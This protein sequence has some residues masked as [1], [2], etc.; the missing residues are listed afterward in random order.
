MSRKPSLLSRGANAVKKGF[1]RKSF[2]LG[3]YSVLATA[4]VIAI[5]IA[6]NLLVGA[7]PSVYTKLDT[8]NQELFTITEQTKKIVS[9]LEADVTVYWIVQNGAENS[10][11]SE[12][13]DRY[14]SLSGHL[15]VVKRD[16]VVHPNFAGQYTSQAVYNNSLV[17]ES[18]ER[19]QYISFEDIVVTDY[20]DYYYTGNYTQEFAG[21]SALTSAI[22][23]VTSDSL[24]TVYL[25]SGHGEA[26]LNETVQSAIEKEN[27]VLQELSLLT[28]ESVPED[29]D[30]VMVIS[31]QTDLS[32]R[33]AEMLLAYLQGGGSLLMLTDY[34][35]SGLPTLMGIMEQYGV[36]AVD[37]IVV[38]GDSYY[39]L[40]GYPYYL[41]PELTT[42][43]IT[44]PLMEGGYSAIMPVAQ[45]LTV[46]SSPRD[47]LSITQLLTT[48]STAYAK[49]SGYGM[50]THEKEEGDIDGPFALGVAIEEAV[51]EGT[52]QIAWFTSSQM[53]DDG[54]N[55]LVSGA[56]HNLFINALDWMCERENSISIRT[57]SLSSET[58]I[59]PDAA[60]SRWS[61]VMIGVIPAVILC[62]GLVVMVTRRRR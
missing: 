7:I 54:I 16:P 8:T 1:T 41:L 5:V 29:A 2:R 61:I 19:S 48:S 30:C 24:P 39:Y 34:V 43:A 58:L 40:W 49:L 45:G 4:I 38:E 37:G 42:H 13:L 14:A 46:D 28:V 50:T 27:F 12:L 20:S 10:L 35:E 18:G 22:D 33:E 55:Q 23:Y 44:T 25:L 56:N 53:L 15:K 51:E 36:T 6:V 59:V 62:V 21:E 11:V 47:T 57:K 52:T 17:V 3:G 31:P 32:D 26:V 9:G 60:A